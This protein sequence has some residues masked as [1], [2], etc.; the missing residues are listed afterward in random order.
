MNTPIIKTKPSRSHAQQARREAFLGLLAGCAVGL[1]VALTLYGYVAC[2][3]NE[4]IL[5]CMAP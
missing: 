5:R 3:A 2:D 4:S 1:V